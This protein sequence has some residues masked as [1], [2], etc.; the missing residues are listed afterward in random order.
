MSIKFFGQFLIEQGEVDASHVREALDLMADVNLNLGDLALGRG[1]LSAR[2]TL[3]ISA[4]QRHRDLCFGELAVEL[5]LLEPA[6]LAELVAAQQAA[7]LPIGQALAR[8]GYV[9]SDR[10]GTLLDA[11]KTD[12][13]REGVEPGA[14]PL[15]LAR[16]PA[17][18][19]LID[20]LPRLLMRIAR[21]QAKVG[22]FR[23]LEDAEDFGE[24]HV[25]LSVRGDLN[26]EVGLLCDPAFAEA[27]A[28]A[29]SGLSPRDLDPEMVA[30]GVGE[31]LNVV[32]G[33][34]VSAVTK[35]GQRFSLGP[36][37]YDATLSDGWI[38]DL[39][40]GTGRAALVL[41]LF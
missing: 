40:V 10:L 41:S 18:A 7:H 14:L 26:L 39:A 27:L 24:Y 38:V 34:A 12:Q 29:T 1:Y 3:E 28:M 36:P 2:Q 19:P 21:M 20:L 4:A 37:D 6:Q 25:S 31:F 15:C 5:G 17:T 9:A 23:A 35:A 11:Y 22:T 16:H 8:L 32:A 33:N 30:D 13:S